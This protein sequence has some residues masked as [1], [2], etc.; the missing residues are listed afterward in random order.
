[1][2]NSEQAA[3]IEAFEREIFPIWMGILTKD[4]ERDKDLTF[5]QVN[6]PGQVM[7]EVLTTHKQDLAI[8][9]SEKKPNRRGY[10]QEKSQD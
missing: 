2:D 7:F 3:S 5:E 4:A 8:I 6:A 9:R 1:M 10:E